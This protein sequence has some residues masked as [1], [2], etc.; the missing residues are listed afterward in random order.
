[1]INKDDIEAEIQDIEVELLAREYDVK[2]NFGE[3]IFS[4][5]AYEEE[6]LERLKHLKDVLEEL[7]W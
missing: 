1:M 2:F 6:L 4:S 3:E 5:E 7:R